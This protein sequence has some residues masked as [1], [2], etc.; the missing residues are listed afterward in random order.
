MTYVAHSFNMLPS[1]FICNTTSKANE[2]LN[3][4][5]FSVDKGLIINTGV[6]DL[7][8]LSPEEIITKQVK[9]VNTACKVFLDK[10]I[11]VSSITPRLDDLGRNINKINDAIDDEIK[12]LPN[13]IHVYNGYLENTKYFHDNK[14]LNKKRGIPALAKNIKWGLRSA[15]GREKKEDHAVHNSHK[16]K[17][18]QPEIIPRTEE[19]NATVIN[20]PQPEEMLNGMQQQINFITDLFN[21]VIQSN[22]NLQ[23]QQYQ[24]V[25]YPPFPPF[26]NPRLLNQA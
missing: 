11:I 26:Y 3:S 8:R 24:R 9:L 4:P 20:P 22:V 10:K 18:Q 16:V 7:E 12:N 13:V 23:Q 14:H 21:K 6:N 2:I 15:F 19:Q 5:R 25:M 17:K 1:Y